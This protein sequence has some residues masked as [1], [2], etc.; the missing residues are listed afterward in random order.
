[1]PRVLP[2]NRLQAVQG[3]AGFEGLQNLFLQY[4]FPKFLYAR[5]LRDRDVTLPGSGPG[6][7]AVVRLK[8]QVLGQAVEGY[9]LSGWVDK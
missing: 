1:M 7:I 8:T 5:D 6:E 4:S 2:D 3:G 9:S